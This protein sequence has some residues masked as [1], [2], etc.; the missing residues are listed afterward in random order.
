MSTLL[1]PA[2]AIIFQLLF[3]E[4]LS[5]KASPFKDEVEASEKQHMKKFVQDVDAHLCKHIEEYRG[6][7]LK[8]EDNKS[9]Q[10]LLQTLW[11]GSKAQKLG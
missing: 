5:K 9:N 2:L 11:I 4:L 1:S 8:K 6:N 10:D 7:K 3:S